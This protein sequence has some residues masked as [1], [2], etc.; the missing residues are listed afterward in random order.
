[1]DMADHHS[2]Q[3]ALKGITYFDHETHRFR[4]GDLEID[5]DRIHAI[6]SPGTSTVEHAVPAR[7]WVCTPGLVLANA[8]AGE[9]PIDDRSERWLSEGVTTAAILCATARAC[10][11]A[12][13]RAR[14]RLVTRLSLNPFARARSQPRQPDAQ[15]RAPELRALERLSALVRRNGGRL[16]IAMHCA[17]IASAYELV[18][19]QNVAAAL[20]LELSFVLS[21]DASTARAF[22]ERFYS[23]ETH[24]LDYMQLLRPG[25]TILGLSELTH[26]DIAVLTRSGADVPG[27]NAIA[28]PQR[29]TRGCGNASS[30]TAGSAS[31]PGLLREVGGYA[32][33]ADAC[34]DTA[35][36]SAASALGDR[37]CG[38][39]APG[40]RA[41][42]CLFAPPARHPLGSGSGSEAFIGLFETQ[43][44][45]AVVVGGALAHGN[46]DAPLPD[47]AGFNAEHSRSS[48]RALPLSFST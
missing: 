39:I 48:A 2:P 22:R 40:M 35:T 13:S 32:D 41:D 31:C 21:T 19:A 12:A 30:E 10:I 44:P 3:W 16:S 9:L 27:L 46:L 36:T 28:L 7:E 18:Y 38:R 8:Q 33:N 5:G 6:R 14:L 24:L 26:A 17:A 29:R 1:M 25:T 23:S 43:R 15:A 37:T 42:L 11:A 4:V 20:R 45:R 47:M 34:V